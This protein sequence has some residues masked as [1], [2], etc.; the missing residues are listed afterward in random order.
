MLYGTTY[1]FG[2]FFSVCV[3]HFLQILVLHSVITTHSCIFLHELNAEVFINLTLLRRNFDGV[4]GVADITTS[5]FDSISGVANLVISQFDFISGVANITTFKFDSI[6]WVT[7]ALSAELNSISF[8]EFSMMMQKVM[9]NC[10]CRFLLEH[11]KNTL[12]IQS[13]PF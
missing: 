4:S 1:F 13:H 7:Y 6:S 3:C 11:L 12:E 9:M 8:L 5:K 10:V 2:R